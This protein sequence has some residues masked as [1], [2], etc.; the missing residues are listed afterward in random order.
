MSC[1]AN[2][3]FPTVTNYMYKNIVTI[4]YR[5]VNTNCRYFKLPIMPHR[6]PAAAHINYV[7]GF[8]CFSIQ[9]KQ[10]N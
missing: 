8:Q 9:H 5:N 7:P 1:R 3:L 4:S 10:K 6:P 2:F